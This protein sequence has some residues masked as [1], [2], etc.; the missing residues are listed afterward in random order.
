LHESSGI[1]VRRVADFSDTQVPEHAHDWPV[2][3]IFVLAGY[4]NQTE[5][6]QRLID[7]PSSVLYR[8]GSAHRNTALPVGFE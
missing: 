4:L 8:T 2:L 7:G 6:G 5:L 3:S 1:I